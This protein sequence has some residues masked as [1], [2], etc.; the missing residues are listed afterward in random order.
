MAELEARL[1]GVAWVASADNPADGPSRS[2]PARNT[3]TPAM[4]GQRAG[5]MDDWGLTAAAV[6]RL[7]SEFGPFSVDAFASAQSAVVPRFWTANSDAFV[8]SWRGE[9]LWLVPPLRLVH[10]ALVQLA[11][12]QASGVVVVPEWAAQPW[13][14]LLC[15]M[16]TAWRQLQRWDVRPVEGF[17]ELLVQPGS[18]LWAVQLD[19]SR[20]AAAMWA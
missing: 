11:A 8:Q 17:A 9:H 1:V 7:E 6:H 18:K 12:A 20:A 2:S 10:R 13:W 5:V 3:P 14:P 15:E 4:A 19:G 16:A